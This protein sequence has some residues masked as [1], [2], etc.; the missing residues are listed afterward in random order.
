MSQPVAL[1]SHQSLAAI[2]DAARS[3]RTVV[4]GVALTREFRLNLMASVAREI[5]RLQDELPIDPGSH[6]I[7]RGLSCTSEEIK[8][9]LFDPR[10][11]RL[12]FVRGVARRDTMTGLREGV[13][14]LIV[15]RRSDRARLR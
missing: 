2:E 10:L 7:F 6:D 15:L 1:S 4:S 5:R 11:E 9:L 12:A 14:L 3:D 13:K 8:D